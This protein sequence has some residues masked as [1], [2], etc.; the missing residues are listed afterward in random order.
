MEP[1]TR[2]AARMAGL[3]RYFT[4]TPCPH[5]HIAER[6]VSN[7]QCVPCGNAK[8]KAQAKRNPGYHAKKTREWRRRNP[9][10]VRNIH[11]RNRGLPAPTRPEPPACECC[12]AP[13]AGRALALDHDHGT[14][15]FRG[16]L[17][18]DCNTGIGRLGDNVAGIR[19]AI[20][21]LEKT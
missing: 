21:Y 16:W 19:R 18:F 6:L 3:T 12:G 17:C 1:I 10:A 14:G 20:A 4:G 13:P 9:E 15:A 11:R 2:S 5:G 7:C 8:V